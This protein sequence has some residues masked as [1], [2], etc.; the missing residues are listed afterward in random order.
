[1]ATFTLLGVFFS[2]LF[3]QLFNSSQLKITHANELCS[4]S[5]GNV[6][7]VTNE[8]EFKLYPLIDGE[9]VKKMLV[10]NE[11]RRKLGSFQI[12]APCTCC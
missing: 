3:L 7:N 12:C 9:K 6:L 8:E 11:T 4:S 10:M 1:M 5:N 2:L